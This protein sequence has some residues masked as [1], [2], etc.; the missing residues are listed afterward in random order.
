MSIDCLFDNYLFSYSATDT[1]KGLWINV[2]TDPT[3]ILHREMILGNIFTV[4]FENNSQMSFIEMH[5][6][7]LWVT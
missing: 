4:A 7:F 5:A 3:F 1:R 2:L 6:R